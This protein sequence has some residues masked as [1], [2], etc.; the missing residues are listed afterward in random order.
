MEGGISSERVKKR[1]FR[2]R[3]TAGKGKGGTYL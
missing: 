3:E 2:Q 1:V